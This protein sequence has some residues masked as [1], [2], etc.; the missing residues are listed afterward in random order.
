M[1]RLIFDSAN[2]ANWRSLYQHQFVPQQIKPG[3]RTLI[4]ATVLP[5]LAESRILLAR[6]S[7]QFAKSTWRNGGSLTPLID[8]GVTGFAE[9]GLSSYRLPCNAA[10]LLIFPNFSTAYKL[11]FSCPW[12]FD[13]ITLTLY[14]YIGDERDSTED[15]IQELKTQVQLLV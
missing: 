13:E 8:C 6:T 5:V 11:R 4:P 10:R 12:W 9:T 15:L 14:E 1:S 2:S 3:E 7:S